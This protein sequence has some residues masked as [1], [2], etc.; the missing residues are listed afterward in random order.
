MLVKVLI[1][2]YIKMEVSNLGWK[3]VKMGSKL[4]SYLFHP[5]FILFYVFLLM[6]QVNPYQFSIQDPKDKGLLIITVFI[7]S[8]FF[9]LVSIL[10]MRGLG[11][12]KSFEMKDK[13]ERIG[14]FIATGIFY[15]WLLTNIKGN[16]DVPHAFSVIVLGTVM[17]LFIGFALNTVSKVSLH[18]IGMGGLI[19]AL[20]L[21]KFQ[22]GYEFFIVE[23]PNIGAY[24]INV[25]F[26]LLLGFSIA[27][28]VGTSRLVLK[29]HKEQDVYGGFV[30][31]LLAQLLAI[32]ILL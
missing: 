16:D 26:L 24:L 27:G 23:I 3:S 22:F 10:I 19:G 20:L 25:N 4:L 1:R 13:M 15:L 7:S 9:P 17:G 28:L 21:I 5:I 14:P 6:I 2:K 18:S 8:V 12:I 29:A 30:I 32:I 11:F 31:G